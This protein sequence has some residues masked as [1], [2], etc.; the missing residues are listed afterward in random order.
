MESDI[1]K[2]K[3]NAPSIKVNAI[4]TEDII[5]ASATLSDATFKGKFIESGKVY[6]INKSRFLYFVPSFYA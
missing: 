1:M 5:M 4:A 3:Y 6:D 2:K